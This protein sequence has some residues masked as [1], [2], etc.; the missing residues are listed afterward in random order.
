MDRFDAFPEPCQAA[1]IDIAFNCGTFM[2][3][4]TIQRALN[5]EGMYEKQTWTERWTAA[6]AD[7][8][9]GDDPTSERNLTVK[10]WFLEG[11][12]WDQRKAS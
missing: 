2:K 3:F 11:A 6:A 10:A 5:G 4:V 8:G 1:L 12:L 7:C 9:R